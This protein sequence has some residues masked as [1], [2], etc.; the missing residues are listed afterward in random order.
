M[1]SILI[2]GGTGLIGSKLIKALD[3]SVYNI[4]VLTRGKSS[5]IDGIHYIN[6]DPNKLDL[7]LSKIGKIFGVVNLA[8]QSV[9]GGR[10]TS[11]YKR[12]IINSRVNSTK[13]LYNQLKK[14]KVKPK[15]YIAASA[16]GYYKENTI[17]PQRE[18]DTSA[19]SFLGNVTSIWE[20]E[21]T[22]IKSLGIRTVILRIGL[23]LSK[24]GG[25]LN[26]LYPLFKFF[27]GVPVGKGTQ[28]ISWIHEK[29]MVNIII[30]SIENNNIQGVYNAVSPQ[31]VDNSFFTRALLKS[32]KRFSYPS[33]F[34]APS[35]IVKLLFGEQSTLVL[36]GLNISSKKI[37]KHYNFY[38]KNLDEALSNIFK[39]K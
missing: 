2:T 18:V 31:V 19:N 11:S 14:I 3:K 37:E 21:S 38:F 17:T 15:V 5:F 13:T 26:K 1:K 36:N 28:L 34:R 10:W 27:L 32:I 7:D 4:Y 8:G 29:D 39:K 22:K 20:K 9:D 25:I 6:W 35:F 24:D 30:N 16:T 23:V 12:K 33:L